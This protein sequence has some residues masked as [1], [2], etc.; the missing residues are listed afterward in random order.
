MGKI[1]IDEAIFDVN[2]PEH[3]QAFEMQCLGI[4]QPNGTIKHIQH[5]SLR[6]KLEKPYT[7]VNIMMLHKVSQ[8]WLKLHNITQ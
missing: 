8:A 5:P 2:N 6:F 1:Y 7:S 3:L 4:K